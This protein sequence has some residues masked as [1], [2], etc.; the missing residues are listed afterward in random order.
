MKLKIH[1][2]YILMAGAILQLIG[3]GLSSALPTTTDK[4]AVQQ[5]GYEALMGVGFGLQ[6]STL[7][8]FAPLIVKEADLGML[9]ATQT[10]S[11]GFDIFR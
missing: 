5:Y 8:I 10:I 2:M 7:T 6:M 9:I 11:L 4:I 3:V 1:H